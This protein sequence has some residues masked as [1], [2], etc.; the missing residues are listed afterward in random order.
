MQ[1]IIDG[2]RQFRAKVYEPQEEFFRSLAA[3]QQRPQALFITC[4]DSRI[5]PNLL[6][7]TE[8][9]DLFIVRNAGNIIPPYGPSPGATT[10]AIEYAV[11]V[12]KVKHIILCG[13][14]HCGAMGALLHP[15]SLSELP[16]VSA[17][18]A[19]AESTRQVMKTK[20]PNAP[21]EEQRAKAAFE[22]VHVQLD[23]LRTHPSVKAA[24]AAGGL[25][26]H[27]W[28]YAI[29]SGD[30]L[31][32]EPNQDRFR[33]LMEDSVESHITQERRIGR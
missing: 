1:K 6:T 26:L 29:E 16:A 23:H 18:L 13:H 33:S 5:D 3:K 15:E 9:G 21:L 27:G 28:V 19:Y 30:I 32:Y 24:M 4:S 31:A 8:P 22:N 25:T 10:A 12:L 17:W 20:Y 7:Q 2:Y 11:A 14:S